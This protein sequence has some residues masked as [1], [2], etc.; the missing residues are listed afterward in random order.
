MLPDAAVL[1]DQS[2]YVVLTVGADGTVV[3]KEVQV[4]D[5]RGGLR[6]ISSGLSPDAKVI[7]DGLLYAAPGSK[8]SPKDGA[9][10]YSSTSQDAD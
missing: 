3:P 5:L 1:P 2:S 9:I 6:V 10:R 7:I 4:G 8:V